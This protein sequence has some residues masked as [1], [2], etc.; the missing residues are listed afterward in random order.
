LKEFYPI[1][2]LTGATTSEDQTSVESS[3]YLSLV[4]DIKDQMEWLVAEALDTVEHELSNDDVRKITQHLAARLVPNLLD[5]AHA[6]YGGMYGVIEFGFQRTVYGD[7]E[8][9]RKRT[10]KEKATGNTVGSTGPIGPVGKQGVQGTL[11]TTT[12]STLTSVPSSPYANS[13]YTPDVRMD[14]YGRNL[15]NDVDQY[16]RVR[17][18]S[19]KGPALKIK[20]RAR[21]KKI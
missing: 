17:K 4:D 7:M 15:Y 3:A 2:P 19:S 14:Q 16:G 1:G 11:G 21:T 8:V 5:T 12:S 9:L 13:T 18:V 10:E 20:Q 6:H